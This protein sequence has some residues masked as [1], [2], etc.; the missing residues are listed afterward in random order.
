M[1]SPAMLVAADLVG[2][3]DIFKI[4]GAQAIAAMAFGTET[5]PQVYKLFGPGSIY[6]V[7][8]KIWAASAGLPLAI[9]CPPGPSEVL[10]IADETAQPAFVAADPVAGRTR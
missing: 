7:A 6:V 3:R 5:V 2:L 9:D 8:A 1:L 4:G 10:I